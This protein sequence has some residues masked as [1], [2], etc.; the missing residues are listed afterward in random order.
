MS[1]T[2]KE[3]ADASSVSISTA[4]RALSGHPGINGKTATR[5]RETAQRM[6]YRF[7]QSDLSARSLEGTEVGIFC[8][9]MGSSLTALP[10]VAAA[11]GG[12]E[13]TLAEKGARTIYASIPDLENPPES[14]TAKLPE[15]LIL[16]G[17]MQGDFLTCGSKEFL[18]S[19]QSR[20]TVWLLGKPR[21]GWGD[22]VGSNDYEVG[23]LAAKTLLNAGHRRLAF[24]NPKPDHLIFQRREDGF[25]ATARREG[26]ESVECICEPPGGGWEIPLEVPENVDA[27]EGSID[28]LLHSRDRPTGVFAA[29][30]TIAVLAYR[31]LAARGLVVGKDIS[32][33]SG[34]NDAAL[35]AGLH[36]ALTTC[37]ISAASI[38]EQAVRQLE[39]R[40]RTN[41]DLPETEI[42]LSPEMRPASSV[43][44]L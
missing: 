4:S 43:V 11:I 19:L 23:A 25:R 8:L 18:E 10:T 22:V 33:V 9:G 5:I 13:A 12:A 40:L 2:L 34:N 16:A 44:N 6:N 29:A 28:Q 7:R 30:D 38:G 42:W 39:M 41:H 24:L 31:A 27:I 32:M 17:A 20:A 3:I 26:A 14:V 36:P 35:I 15:A 21:G 37:D 1:V